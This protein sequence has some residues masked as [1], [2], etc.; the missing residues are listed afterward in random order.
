M[1]DA[2][3]WRRRTKHNDGGTFL[4]RL[5]RLDIEEI[6]NEI[7]ES[8]KNLPDIKSADC[9]RINPEKLINDIL[10]IKI[11][12]ERL[13][14]DGKTFGLTAYEDLGVEVF[15]ETNES[16]YYFLDGNTILV[17][18]SLRNDISKLG[19][20]NFS[21]MHEAS[22]QILKR[23]YPNDYGVVEKGQSLIHY[24]KANSE[25]KKP[26]ED[27]E[28]WQANTLASAILLPNDIV[29]RGMFMFELGDK[30]EIL[31]KV[32]RPHQY[33]RFC[34]LAQFLGVSKQA[35]AIRMK[36]LGLLEKDYLKEPYALVE[37]N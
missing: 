37:V 17:D 29:K 7:T 21:M 2:G 28:E 11:E 27:W 14:R 19:R 30:I 8:Y 4:K 31:N 26:I 36:H 32:F 34:C 25:R 6:A 5:S 9:Y 15:T 13:S 3:S 23:K 20:C 1:K 22:H 12:Y 18:K 24:Y 33:E 16:F 35:L 10:K